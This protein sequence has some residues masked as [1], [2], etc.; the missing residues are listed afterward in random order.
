[1]HWD[2]REDLRVVVRKAVVEALQQSVCSL[3]RSKETDREAAPAPAGPGREGAA[4]DH[5]KGRFFRV[6][7]SQTLAPD[8]VIGHTVIVYRGCIS[9]DSLGLVWGE[10]VTFTLNQMHEPP[11]NF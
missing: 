8:A 10:N 11:N 5:G 7:D 9:L 3:Q 1:M 2:R 4:S 6:R